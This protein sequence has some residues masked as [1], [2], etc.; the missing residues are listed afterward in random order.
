MLPIPRHLKDILVPIGN[1]NSEFEVTGILTCTCN[2]TYFKIKQYADKGTYIIYAVC[3]ECSKEYL[4]FDTNKHGWDGFVCGDNTINVP[5]DRF[6]D[7]SCTNCNN[8][9]HE[10]EICINS[11]GFE[12]F[13][14]EAVNSSNGKFTEADWTEGFE[15]IN[16]DIQCKDCGH[17]TKQFVNIE[18]M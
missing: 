6:F 10:L 8:N 14:E 11:Q 12:D 2:S 16:I 13:I 17:N 4:V 15:W 18:T 3:S 9:S 5:M 1:N 7:Y